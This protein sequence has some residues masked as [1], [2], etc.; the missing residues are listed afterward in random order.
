MT[1]LRHLS[2]VGS[3]KFYIFSFWGPSQPLLHV[4]HCRADRPH[5]AT[6]DPQDVP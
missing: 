2:S 6:K 4:V 5:E 1:G 3:P